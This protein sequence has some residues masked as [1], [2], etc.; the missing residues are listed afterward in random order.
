M[1]RK[2]KMEIPDK[3]EPGNRPEEV[4]LVF[5][6]KD[7]KPYR[8]DTYHTTRAG[9][10]W[11]GVDSPGYYCILG[12]KKDARTLSGKKPLVLL[13]ED[14]QST[15]DRFFERLVIR[16]KKYLCDM[17]FA[18]LEKNPGFENSL[19]RFVDERKMDALYPRDSSEFENINHATVLINQR[20]KDEGLVIPKDSILARQAGSM[21]PDDLKDRPEERFYAVMALFRVLGSFEYYP[22]RRNSR[23]E[24]VFL[25][26]QNRVKK[27]KWDGGYYEFTVE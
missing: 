21:T 9:I 24:V 4:V 11:P 23:G 14:E 3:I 15:L 19:R 7:G 18:N 16:D 20:L 12:L 6:A 5:H 1:R 10:S 22:W 26:F 8:I 2:I 25:N 27:T 13:D 17:A